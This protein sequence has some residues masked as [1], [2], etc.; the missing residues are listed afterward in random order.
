MAASAEMLWIDV[1]EHEESGE[2][3]EALELARQITKLEPD[4]AAAWKMVARMT[5]P[6]QRRGQQEMPTLA[7]AATALGALR[8]VVEIEPNDTESW[9]LGGIL[10][11]DHLGM[12]EEALVWWQ[13]RRVVEPSEVT[14]VVEQIAILVRLGMYTEAGELLEVLF[15]DGMDSPDSRQLVKMDQVR[16]MVSKAAKMEKDEV[17]RPQNPKHPRWEIIDRMKTRKPLSE[18][19]FLFTFVAPIVFLIGTVA[20][21]LLGG[22]QFGFILVFLIILGLFMGVSRMGS[23]LLHSLNRHALDLD[24]ALDVEATSGKVCVPEDIRGSKLYVHLLGKRPEGFRERH[25]KIVDADEKIGRR[26]KP[27]LPDFF[28]VGDDSWW[29]DEAESGDEDSAGEG[30]DESEES[31]EP[32]ELDELED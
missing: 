8:R 20:M 29:G 23:G 24:R 17:F 32:L 5:L 19:F 30:S 14:P 9:L 4:H 2:R 22:T 31:D 10:L 7:Q 11:V 13:K 18:T 15:S 27:E 12:L 25:E 28:D 16:K 6:P 21:Q 1:L 3:G 26:W